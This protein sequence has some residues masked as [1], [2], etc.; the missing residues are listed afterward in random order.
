MIS[1]L[2]KKLFGSANDRFVK[3]LG[4]QVQRINALEP[5]MQRLTDDELRGRTQWLRER[6]NGGEKLDNLLVD[7]FA[8]VRE[9]GRRA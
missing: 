4:A 5:Q 2:A 8:T 7:A 9:A 3:T 6:L 1:S